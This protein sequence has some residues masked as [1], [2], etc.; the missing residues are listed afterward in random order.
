MWLLDS[1]I[2]L[3]G[4]NR[5]LKKRPPPIS[6]E[7]QRLNRRTEDNDAL[8]HNYG[9]D[10]AIYCRTTSIGCCCCLPSETY[11]MNGATPIFRSSHRTASSTT[12][13]W[14]RWNILMCFISHSEHYGLI[15]RGYHIIF[16]GLLFLIILCTFHFFLRK[17]TLHMCYVFNVI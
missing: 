5:V 10:T 11:G 17:Y 4:N 2:Q 8:S 7:E 12:G 13:G 1:A 9:Q 16:T 3:Q 14:S 6:D 15:F